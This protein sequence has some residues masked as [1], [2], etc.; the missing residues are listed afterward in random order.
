MKT[1]TIIILSAIATL[2]NIG[3]FWACAYVYHLFSEWAGPP[4][5]FT[6]LF[7]TVAWIA[8]LGGIWATY[9][10]KHER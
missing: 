4:A 1:N 6:C 7:S 2:I 3:V 8:A 5:T 10:T 9:D